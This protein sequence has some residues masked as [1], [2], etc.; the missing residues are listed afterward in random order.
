MAACEKCWSDAYSRM[1]ADTSKTQTDHYQDLLEE[2][3]DKPCLE[4]RMSHTKVHELKIWPREFEAIKSGLKSFEFR[5]DD[6][7]YKVGDSILLREW[8]KINGYSGRKIEAK[9]TYILS[10][11]DFGI[12]YGYCILSITIKTDLEAG[13]IKALVL[14]ARDASEWLIGHEK[15]NLLESALEPFK[16]LK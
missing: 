15:Y 8:T 2:R 6:R 9:I 12:P 10:K 14:A 13:A 3:K 5:K 1:M 16:E 4:E 11:T 7:E